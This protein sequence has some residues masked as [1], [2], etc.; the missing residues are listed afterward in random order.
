MK[1]RAIRECKCDYCR[2]TWT[3]RWFK[4][5]AKLLIVPLIVLGAWVFK[6]AVEENR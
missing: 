2:Q 1:Q 4:N 5:K 6:K 3:T